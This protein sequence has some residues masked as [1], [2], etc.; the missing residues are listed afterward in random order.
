MEWASAHRARRPKRRSA[1]YEPFAIRASSSSDRDLL[2][3]E[4]SPVSGTTVHAYNEHGELISTTDARGVTVARTVDAADRVTAVSYPDP[5]LDTSFVYD[6]APAECAESLPVGRLGEILRG[7]ASVPYCYDRLGRLARDGELTFAYDGNGNRTQVGYPGNVVASY[8]YDFADRQASLTVQVGS[9]PAQTVVSGASY[10][11]SGPLG[12]LALGNGLTETRSFDRRYAPTGIAVPGLFDRTYAT[13]AVGN[14]TGIDLTAPNGTFPSTYTY[15]DVQ[16]FLTEGGGPWGQRFWAYD[17]I[18]NRVLEDA[19]ES[20]DSDL[21]PATYT[22]ELNPSGGN[23]AK[24]L[25]IDDLLGEEPGSFLA[26][27]YDPAGHQTSIVRGSIEGPG[28]ES[29]LGYDDAGRL[30][31]LERTGS[32]ASTAMTY[33]GRSFLGKSHQSFTDST[34]FTKAEPVYA[35]EGLLYTRRFHQQTT[36]DRSDAD[37]PTTTDFVTQEASHVLYLAGRPVAELTVTQL[38]G[39]TALLFLSADHLGAPMAVTDA[40]GTLVWLGGMEPWGVPYTVAPTGGDGGDG[41]DGGDGGDGD[42]DAATFQLTPRA[43]GFPESG[44]TFLRLP[45]QWDDQ[46]FRSVVLPGGMYYNVH[47]WYAPGVGR[48]SRPDPLGVRGGGLPI[49]NSAVAS[50]QLLESREVN[51]YTYSLQNPLAFLDP[52]GLAVKTLGCGSRDA[53]IQAAAGDADAASQTCLP[54]PLKQP[55]RDAIRSH[56][57]SDEV[58]VECVSWTVSPELGF[59]VCGQTTTDKRKIQVTPAAFTNPSC[60]CLRATILHEFLHVISAFGDN[61]QQISNQEK[62]CFT[63]AQ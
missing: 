39:T 27:G 60:G 56:G 11:P 2:T 34:D 47:R 23:T 13:D 42:A 19:S 59:P 40:A 49:G 3:Q 25:R 22:Y 26:F 16:Y 14:V 57:T 50:A 63:C 31:A 20:L 28:P 55:F 35:S 37:D 6:T 38:D 41:D 29:T 4:V 48:Y 7:G 43:T 58:V 15:Q 8:T 33:D 5:A 51:L 46:T 52:L 21:G 10:L 61:E 45:G 36:R 9:D 44:G 1:P 30:A 54:C 32:T 18:G 12:S 24:L 53:Q 62:K 17:R